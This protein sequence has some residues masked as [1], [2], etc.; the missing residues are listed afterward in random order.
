MLPI[1]TEAR[2]SQRDDLMPYS[3]LPIW[4]IVECADEGC[5]AER[6]SRLSQY[7]RGSRRTSAAIIGEMDATTVVL[8]GYKASVDALGNLLITAATRGAK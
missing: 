1:S 3:P 7:Q 2:T 8:P 4:R 5:A 6:C